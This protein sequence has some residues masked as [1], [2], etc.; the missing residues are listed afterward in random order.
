MSLF[1]SILNGLR[2]SLF[3]LAY[4]VVGVLVAGTLNRVLL[5]EMGL[6]KAL[7]GLMFA[8]P[9]LE[10][11]VRV[12]F[13]YRSDGYPVL[14]KRREPWIILGAVIGGLAVVAVTW[15]TIQAEPGAWVILA[16]LTLA[17]LLYGFGRSL[18]HNSF[19][20]LLTDKYA[21]KTR[22]TVATLFEVVTLIGSVIA[23]GLI[24]AR[25]DVYDPAAL[26][27]VSLVVMG[28]FVLLAL[29]AAPAQEPR[30][31]ALD[32]QTSHVRE[33]P[34]WETVK[35][36]LL[37]D[38]Q[39][40][41]FFALIL[42]A[43]VGTLAQDVWLEGYG[44]EVLGMSVGDTTRLTQYWGPG[45]LISMVLSGLVLLPLLGHMI[46]MR[47][48]FIFSALAFVGVIIVGFAGRAD[49]FRWLVFAMGVGTG[50][51]G[52]GML[53]S[54]VTFSSP[55]RAGLL[56]GVWGMA[57]ALGR[58]LGTFMGG[59]LAGIVEGVT[60]NALLA[61]ASIFA[62]EVAMLMVALVLS[63]RLRLDK[64]QVRQEIAES[65][66]PAPVALQPVRVQ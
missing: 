22:R 38:P 51:A 1:F 43:F 30:N 53:S 31:P 16:S 35:T 64:A 29:I 6:S 55:L 24:G 2:L 14:G 3:A 47:A 13:G 63:F 49:L 34:F 19:Q 48:G 39:V 42:C 32:Q 66:A 9:Y 21:P 36:V 27:Q 62:L 23:G 8:L 18:A 44:G 5:V 56:M 60:G 37:P 54:V 40:R 15:L 7:V 20:A 52:A 61:Y 57:N 58:A 65:A 17:L 25:L 28:L 12:W 33:Q 50:L 41:I 46:V 4:G 26:V 45:V 11:P 10:S 59:A